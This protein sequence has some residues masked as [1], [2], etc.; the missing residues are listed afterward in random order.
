MTITEQDIQNLTP[1]HRIVWR[2]LDAPREVELGLWEDKQ[3][4]L[5]TD[6]GHIMRWGDYAVPAVA[7]A[8]TV[9]I[10]EPALT[11]RRGL[12]IG[13]PGDFLR[14]LVCVGDDEW[15]GWAPEIDDGSTWFGDAEARD[16]IENHGWQ[17]VDDL[18][19][20]KDDE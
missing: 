9:R 1:E 11:P 5:C 12:V 20:E 4:R 3:G 2:C 14:R 17:I 16:L 8:R 19:K 6:A 15:L 7:L 10:I 18:T 13:H